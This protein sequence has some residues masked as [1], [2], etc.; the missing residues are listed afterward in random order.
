MKNKSILFIVLCALAILF[1][2]AVNPFK[3]NYRLRGWQKFGDTPVKVE[4]IQYFIADTPNVIGYKDTDTGELIS[5]GGSVAY[6]QTD[7]QETYRCC[8][9]SEKISCLAGDF[10]SD[11]VSADEKC[12]TGL[13]ELFGVPD[14]LAGAREYMAYGVCPGGGYAELTVVQL[15]KDG[16]IWWKTVDANTIQVVNT[17]LRCILAPILLLIILRMIMVIN[18]EKRNKPIHRLWKS[19]DA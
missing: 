12:T 5:C 3:L 14:S 11:V 15:D 10:S 7:T 18:Q 8:D 13:R 2:Y 9:T 17:A 4:H 19:D 16:Q 1:I 6:V